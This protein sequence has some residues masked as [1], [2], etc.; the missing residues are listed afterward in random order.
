MDSVIS[1]NQNGDLKKIYFIHNHNT[2]NRLHSRMNET[3]KE[4]SKFKD[5]ISEITETDPYAFSAGQLKKIS[6]ETISN[7]IN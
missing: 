6:R 4:W 2:E 5:V 1:D 3:F 7:N